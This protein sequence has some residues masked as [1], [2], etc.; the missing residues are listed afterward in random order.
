MHSEFW[1]GNLKKRDLRTL[2]DN[3]MI[4]LREVFYEVVNSP[5]IRSKSEIL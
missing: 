1:L 5:S 2:K 3:N 4:D